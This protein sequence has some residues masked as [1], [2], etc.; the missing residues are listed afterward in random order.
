[1]SPG[2]D[3]AW[4]PHSAPSPVPACAPP[5]GLIEIRGCSGAGASAWLNDVRMFRAAWEAVTQGT[6][7]HRGAVLGP[8]ARLRAVALSAGEMLPQ[9]GASSPSLAGPGHTVPLPG[10]QTDVRNGAITWRARCLHRFPS[11]SASPARP[12]PAL[13]ALSSS[14]AGSLDGAQTA[15]PSGALWAPKRRPLARPPPARTVWPSPPWRP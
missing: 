8:P 14:A 9:P 7:Q 15:A 12:L 5:L 11:S 10:S 4:P 2:R 6:R 13:P 1:M 3:Q